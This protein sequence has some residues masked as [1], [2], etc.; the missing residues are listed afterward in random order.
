M[1]R[2][3]VKNKFTQDF[4]VSVNPGLNL[5]HPQLQNLDVVVKRKL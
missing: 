4:G 2:E 5:Q 3:E 1:R